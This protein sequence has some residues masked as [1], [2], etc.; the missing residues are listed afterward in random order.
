VSREG[1][2]GQGGWARRPPPKGMAPRRL[3]T[4][5]LRPARLAALVIIAVSASLA[6]G[7]P[8]GAPG[9]NAAVKPLA[10][11][12]ANRPF[13]ALAT[14]TGPCTYQAD[15]HVSCPSPCFP[16]GKIEHNGSLACTRLLLGAINLAQESEHHPGFVLPSN[17][18]RLATTD[19]LFVLVNLERIS[20]GVPPLV[21][22]SPYLN[23]EAS[24]SAHE[25]EDPPSQLAYGPVKVWYPPQGGSLGLGGAWAGNSVNAAAAVFGWFYDDGWGGRGNTW[26][27][28]CTSPAASGCWGHRDQLLGLWAGTDC[29]NCIGGAGFASPAARRWQ[30]SYDFLLVRPVSPTPLIFTWNVDVLPFLP[31]GWERT[32]A[33]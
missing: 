12:A 10:N 32:K 14:S 25:A 4:A 19:Q 27:F 18:Y 20:H 17:Y 15:G 3:Q 13:P 26:N 21:G 11:P 5:L 16:T 30:E 24:G 1:P 22:L 29:R 8:G 33:A 7:V 2:A 23:I 31:N 6:L 28:A 9:A